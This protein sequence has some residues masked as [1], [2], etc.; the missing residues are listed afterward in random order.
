MMR[1]IATF[2]MVLGAMLAS[3]ADSVVIGYGVRNSFLATARCDAGSICL[4][5]QYL[6]ILKAART[7]AGP[8]VA[9]EVRAVATQ[10]A[11]AT[12][13]FVSS[14]ELFVLRPVTDAPLRKASGADFYLV[15][16]SPRDA[17]GSYCLPVRPTS[18]GLHLP[19]GK[20]NAR[21]DSYCFDARLL[22]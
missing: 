7:V 5:A 6:W 15:A 13:Q 1:W 12:P 22:R 16:L 4:D 3:A 8:V 2:A 20:V 11:D 19:P 21:G 9:G 18:V 10:H 14:A 17:A